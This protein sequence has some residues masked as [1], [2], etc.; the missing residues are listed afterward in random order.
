MK[1]I[2]KEIRECESTAWEPITVLILE[3]THRK[4]RGR[5]MIR[6]Y[7][8]KDYDEILKRLRKEVRELYL[9][10]EGV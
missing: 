1:V 5:I 8:D 2:N 9:K 7:D 3:Y 10:E 6:E 4:K